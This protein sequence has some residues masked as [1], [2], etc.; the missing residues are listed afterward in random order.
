MI[1]DISDCALKYQLRG[2][3]TG[4]LPISGDGYDRL[5][6]AILLGDQNGRFVVF[7]SSDQRVAL[8][9][10]HLIYAQL[11]LDVDPPRPDPRVAPQILIQVFHADLPTPQLF[12]ASADTDLMFDYDADEENVQLQEFLF[13]L[14]LPH[15][16]PRIVH[17]NASDGG[18]VFLLS[19]D[20]AM[21]TI[22]IDHL[23]HTALD[24]TP[25][26]A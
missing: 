26:E 3:A 17:F 1:T 5:W 16:N 20:V 23:M 9:L 11:L 24:A 7:D 21:V 19:A 8:N 14:T 22:P 6:R 15:I 2:G 18:K 10:D 4:S 25:P 12:H 13:R